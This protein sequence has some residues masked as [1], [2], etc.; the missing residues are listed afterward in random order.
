MDVTKKNRGL[1]YTIF[2]ITNATIHYIQHHKR[3]NTLYSA[4]Q[5]LQYEYTIFSIT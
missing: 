3:Y 1:Q 2:S 5:T 4:S